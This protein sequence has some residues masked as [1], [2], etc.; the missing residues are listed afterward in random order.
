[1][2]LLGEDRV[3]WYPTH[4][5]LS[6]FKKFGHKCL[7]NYWLYVNHTK[8]SEERPLNSV[9]IKVS[10]LI[11]CQFTLEFPSIENILHYTNNSSKYIWLQNLWRMVL[12]L[13]HSMINNETT[14]LF[15]TKENEIICIH[16]KQELTFW[17]ASKIIR[18]HVVFR[19]SVYCIIKVG[20]WG[21]N[22][23]R[24]CV[25]GNF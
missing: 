9:I 10:S 3:C 21:K 16:Y 2:F 6:F 15:S 8:N 14:L 7:E 25:T 11:K 22:S 12:F 23:Y 13:N 20:V 1:M 17:S 24:S 18:L 19:M 4:P 5:S